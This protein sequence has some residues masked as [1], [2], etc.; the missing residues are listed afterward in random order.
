MIPV[1]ALSSYLYCPRKLFIERVLG[2][3]IELP[4]EA[5]IKGS[6][7]HEVY[8]KINKAQEE[9]VKSI[10]SKDWA[11]IYEIYRA[12]YIRILKKVIITNKEQ[13]RLIETPL[14]DFFREIKPM[15]ENEAEYRAMGIFDFA[16]RTGFLGE[17]LWENLIP[18]TKP[19]YRISSDSLGLRGIIDELQ[20]YENFF[21]PV[22]FKTGKMPNEGVWPGHKIQV[23]AY[24]LLLEENF[25]VQIT[26]AVVRYLDTN[27]TRDVLINPFLK[28]EV[29]SLI[30]R[31]QELLNS[32]EIPGFAD[33]ENKCSACDLK[34]VCHDK[35]ALE[36][37]TKD[38]NR[39]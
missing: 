5:I 36:L 25:G 33:N 18:K 9:L 21:V 12:R 17:E 7:R 39:T 2:I 31:V 1:T 28:E 26:K 34:D 37:K 24:A 19:E 10:K 11:F 6:I 16:G 29:K 30:I 3:K 15:I 32:A 14:T 8:E 38:L 27:T 20:V 23:G 13:L 22:E 35:K 4:K